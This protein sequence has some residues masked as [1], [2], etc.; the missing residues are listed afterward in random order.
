MPKTSDILRILHGKAVIL[1]DIANAYHSIEYAPSSRQYTAFWGVQGTKF[2]FRRCCQ[3]MAASPYHFSTALSA[4]FT[5]DR[6]KAFWSEF[7]YTYDPIT[8]I[9]SNWLILYVDD[10][11]IAVDS[12]TLIKKNHFVLH[13]LMKY[14]LKINFTKL[15]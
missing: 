15:K 12:S 3:G 2:Q 6:F 5:A 7:G 9:P 4:I 8:D 1:I 14:K 13:T 10:C 11:L